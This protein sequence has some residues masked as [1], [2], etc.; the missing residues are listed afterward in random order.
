[1][2]NILFTITISGGRQSRPRAVAVVRSKT[3]EFFDSPAHASVRCVYKYYIRVGVR[4]CVCVCARA[5]N[6]R[7]EMVFSGTLRYRV[8]AAAQS[9][10]AVRTAITARLRWKSKSITR[11]S[12]KSRRQ[13]D[14]NYRRRLTLFDILLRSCMRYFILLSCGVERALSAPRRVVRRREAKPRTRRIFS[15]KRRERVRRGWGGL[16]IVLKSFGPVT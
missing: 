2:Y 16:S 9:S 12:N 6:S 3:G 14:N 11:K 4:V 15:R 5:L 13:N 7:A 1:M 8:S 10:S